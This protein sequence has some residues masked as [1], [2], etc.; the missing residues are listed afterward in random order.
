MYEEARFSIIDSDT[1]TR[2]MYAYQG[3]AAEVLRAARIE[4]SEDPRQPFDILEHHEELVGSAL[5]SIAKERMNYV[6]AG[7]P[8]PGMPEIRS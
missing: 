4:F 2:Q 3:I 6:K 5:I 7:I 1:T 8:D